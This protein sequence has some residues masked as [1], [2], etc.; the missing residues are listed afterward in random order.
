[1]NPKIQQK[2]AMKSSQE[3]GSELV[4]TGPGTQAKGTQSGRKLP[5]TPDEYAELNKKICDA[6]SSWN[7]DNDMVPGTTG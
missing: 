3:Q 6:E 2:S 1:M 7:A 4:M 5:R